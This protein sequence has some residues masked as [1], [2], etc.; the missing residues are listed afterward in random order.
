MC[1]ESQKPLRY[2]D[3]SKFQTYKSLTSVTLTG[4]ASVEIG[5]GLEELLET[6]ERGKMITEPAVTRRQNIADESKA[7]ASIEKHRNKA[8]RL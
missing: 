6:R 8:F 1:S 2:L 7:E 3:K 5:L 4:E